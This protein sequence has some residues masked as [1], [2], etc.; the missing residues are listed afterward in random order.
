MTPKNQRAHLTLEN[1]RM[2][3]FDEFI[4]YSLYTTKIYS[5]NMGGP[6]R[7]SIVEKLAFFGVQGGFIFSMVQFFSTPKAQGA[8]F[9]K[10]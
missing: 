2:L 3:K 1:F 9:F 8:H 4:M 7:N 10:G 6:A 5:K